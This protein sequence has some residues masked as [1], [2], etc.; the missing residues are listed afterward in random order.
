MVRVGV[1]GSCCAETGQNR[2][3]GGVGEGIGTL[4]PETGVT[5]GDRGRC[6]LNREGRSDRM[7]DWSLVSG[8]CR[9]YEIAHKRKGQSDGSETDFWDYAAMYL[10]AYR[11]YGMGAHA[12]GSRLL[13]PRRVGAGADRI[14]QLS[15]HGGPPSE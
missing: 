5:H 3:S 4:E 1:K 9:L 12:D 2:C 14:V 13:N 8:K 7:A 10:F 6:R 15:R 11:G